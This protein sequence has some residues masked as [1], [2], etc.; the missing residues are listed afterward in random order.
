MES[1]NYPDLKVEYPKISVKSE[2]LKD[3]FRALLNDIDLLLAPVKVDRPAYS[4]NLNMSGLSVY[5]RSCTQV[6]IHRPSSITQ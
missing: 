3:N 4:P 2:Q 1:S 6:Y 5:H